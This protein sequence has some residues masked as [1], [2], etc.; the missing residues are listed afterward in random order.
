MDDEIQITALCGFS[1]LAVIKWMHL[2]SGLI[3][4]MVMVL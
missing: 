1:H 3:M 4:V 2:W